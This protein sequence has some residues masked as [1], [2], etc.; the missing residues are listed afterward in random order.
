LCDAGTANARVFILAKIQP[1]LPCSAEQGLSL[2]SAA[3]R[4]KKQDLYGPAF[5]FL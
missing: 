3:D 4:E 2:M 5:R 1:F